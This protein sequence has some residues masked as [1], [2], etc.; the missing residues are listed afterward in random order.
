MAFE[1]RLPDIGEGVVEGEIIRWLI[2]V[3]DEVEEDQPM[4]EV[5]T[6]KATVELPSPVKGRVLECRGAEGDTIDVGATLVVIDTG[7][8]EPAAREVSAPAR[9]EVREVP[10][11]T[12]R[13][14]APD[15]VLTTPAVRRLAQ[16]RDIDLSKV[17]GSGPGG[18]ILEEDLESPGETTSE[19]PGPEGAEFQAIPYRA[20][21]RRIGE[22][23]TRS[24]RSAVHYS[25]IEEADVTQLVELRR[26]FL[27]GDEARRITYLP[28]ILKAVVSGLRAFPLLNSSLDEERGEI[29][30]HKRYH[31]GIA[32]ATP[33]GLVVPVVRDVERKPLLEL[34]E[35]VRR[36]TD[37][38]RRGELAAKDLKGSTFTATSLGP[39]GGLAATPVINY[40]EVAIL[41]VHKID[42]RP[43]VRRGNIVIRNMM[44]LSISLDHRVVDGAVGAQFMQHVIRRLEAPGLML[45]END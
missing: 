37:A 39:L 5:M 28:F 10:K 23:L 15:S 2:E 18:R 36:F 20:L 34:S 11:A 42:E 41:A 13:R 27:A 31:I 29:R 43:V 26:R 33:E 45:L 4:V 35:E 24:K 44:N 25:Y 38:A 14:R 8:E 9:P 30:L 16:A 40:P 21:R 7:R 6:D 22:H 1:F 32:T 17:K 12:G 3:G 19:T